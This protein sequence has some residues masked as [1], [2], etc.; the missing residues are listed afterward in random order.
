MESYYLGVDVGSG[1]VR[2]GVF[3]ADGHCLAH[4]SCETQQFRPRPGFV[5]QSSQDIW[6]Q[7]EQAVRK[8]ITEAGVPAERIVG[9]GFDATCSLVA[10][11]ASGA[12]VSVSPS[13]EDD[14]NIIMWMDHRAVTQA[15]EITATGH[16][17]LNYVGGKVS[18]EHEIPKLV[19][20][21]HN[22]PDQ[23]ERAALFLDL[24]D[25]MVARAVGTLY[26]GSAPEKS[27]CTQVCKW[28]YLAHEAR[29]PDD[30][31]AIIGL[32]ELLGRPR[33]QG[34]IRTVGTP[35]GTLS[36]E[37][38][39]AM[40][41]STDVIVATGLIDAHAGALGMLGDDPTGSL[42]VI[43]GT[44]TCHI[45]LSAQPCFVP[46]VWGPYQGAVLPDIWINEGGQSAVGALIDHVIR[47]SANNHSLMSE[48]G[49]R[50]ISHFDL[51]NEHL[52]T[53]ESVDSELTR[54]IHVLDYHHGN[55]S[56][57]A[58]ASLTGMI[59]GLTLETSIDALAVRYLATLQAVSYGTRHI[60][61]TLNAN[62]HDIKRLLVC[63]GVLKNERWL[64]EMADATGLTL[65]IPAE[66]ETVLLGS[67]MLAATACG[68]QPSVQQASAAM[69]TQERVITPRPERRPF[70]DGKYAVYRAMHAHQLEYRQLMGANV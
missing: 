62:G 64:T 11:D 16:A 4:C 58:D 67:A 29:Y 20:L 19:W 27:V 18:P 6:Q 53:L 70:H 8:A 45:A 40:G 61:D 51:L 68:D 26:D 38:A 35:A 37:C 14:Q 12:P 1:S 56:P 36:A 50:Q 7:C 25:Y 47:D 22:R 63:G 57:L 43:A 39:K 59:S 60:V 5:E 48:A 41:L 3:T 54:N 28:F 66:P 10:L 55:R 42:A 69:S 23:F 17:A 65:V 46:G 15:D 13:D 30:L 44:S 31:F 33:M 9:I 2:A 34:A 52:N 49:R 24:T 32:D 21:K